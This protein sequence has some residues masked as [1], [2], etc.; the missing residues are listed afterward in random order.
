[1]HFQTVS[2]IHKS[3]RDFRP[4][5]V[6]ILAFLVIVAAGCSPDAEF[7]VNSVHKL[8]IE[9][10]FLDGKAVPP[11]QMNQMGNAL[12]ALFGTPEEPAFPVG[13]TDEPIVDMANLNLASGA[14]A[15]DRTG[16]HR[17]LY[18][19]HCAHCHGITGDGAG[20]TASFLNP[21]P[22]DFR[23]GKFKFK[24]TRLG[25]P[26]TDKD[27]KTILIN[28]IPGTAMPS[29]RLLDDAELDALVDYVKFLSIRGTVERS[30][31]EEVAQLDE[32]E[33]LLAS[34]GSVPDDEFEDQLG[35]LM[36]DV[37][38]PTL[39]KWTEREKNITEVPDVPANFMIVSQQ[40]ATNGG[41]LFFGKANCAQC[42]GQTGL[43][44]GQTQNY[45]DWTNE[46]LK[47]AK[48]DENNPAEIAEF[49][50]AGALKPRKSRPRNL[51]LRVFRGG[52]TPS[53]LYRRIANGIEGT[54]MPAASGL[55]PDE[56]WALVAYVMEMSLLDEHAGHEH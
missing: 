24:S 14:V 17:G 7:R 42:H 26:P 15:S 56:I 11:A 38:L 45:D 49:L 23:L 22:R 12:V 8:T 29:F 35:Y 30:M 39:D 44:D 4:A 27:L 28:G 2:S 55:E 31:L 48:V 33:S 32:S 40:L 53:D 10:E 25:R 36:D 13:L 47:R 1:M 16:L 50:N 21:Y 19:E 34:K 54:P 3:A 52:G 43:G 9:K 41:P 5:S 6:A 18:R 51:G 20:P 37:V 46:W